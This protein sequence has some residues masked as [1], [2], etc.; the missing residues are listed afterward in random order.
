MTFIFHSGDCT[1]HCAKGGLVATIIV[2][3]TFLALPTVTARADA[4]TAL[5]SIPA[6]TSAL[7]NVRALEPDTFWSCDGWWSFN[8]PAGPYN[9]KY[10]GSGAFIE[11]AAINA[12]RTCL[13]SQTIDTLKK[14]CRQPAQ[15]MSC[16]IKRSCGFHWTDYI[17]LGELPGNPCPSGCTRDISPITTSDY[18]MHMGKI[19]NRRLYQCQ[20]SD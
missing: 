16:S 1:F 4:S 8:V 11:T 6:I 13:L 14:F 15:S 17:T 18:R 10:T 7:N 20:E 12:R 19:Q 5:M 2:L 3:L 9:A